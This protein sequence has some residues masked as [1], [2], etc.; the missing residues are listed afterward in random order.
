LIA[1]LEWCQDNYVH[2]EGEPDGKWYAQVYSMALN[3]EL[4]AIGDSFV[5]AVEKLRKKTEERS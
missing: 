4:E 5:D 1:A 2:L 3:D